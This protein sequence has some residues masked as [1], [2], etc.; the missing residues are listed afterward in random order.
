ME[1]VDLHSLG[2]TAEQIE[3]RRGCIGG[4][5]ANTIMSGD[6]EKV[7]ALWRM[8]RG[9]TQPDDLSDVLPVIMGLYTEPL[10]RAWYEKQTGLRVTLVGQ[11]LMDFDR[12]WMTTTLDGVGMTSTGQDARVYEAKHVSAFWKPD[13]ILAKYLP[14]ATHNML[15]AGYRRC[16]LS[17]FFGSHKWEL[18]E[19]ELDDEYAAALLQAETAFWSCVETGQEPVAVQVK[20]PVAPEALRKVDFTGNNEFADLAADWLAHRTAAK[21]FEAAAKGIREMISDDVGEATGHGLVIK[22]SKSNSLLINP[23]K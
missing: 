1:R 5:D 6:P 4:S 8:K 3:F 9:E 10:N 13:D 7:L 14:Q 18:F 17:V 19:V 2:L 23:A 15:V 20:Q 22:R 21:K 12:P 16:D 11:E